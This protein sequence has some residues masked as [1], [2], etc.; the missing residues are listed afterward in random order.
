MPYNGS[1][2][3]NSLGVPTFPAVTGEYILA[4][5]FNATM[6][7]VF[8]GLS[9]ALPRDG[10]AAMS[11]ALAMANFK[12]TGLAN[13]SNP[14]DAV[15]YSQVFSGGSF[16][17]PVL[18]GVVNG[19]GATSVTVPSPTYED[20]S[21][22][23]V[24][25]SYLVSYYAKLASP[26]LTGI[27]TAPTA[28]YGTDTDQ[29]ATMAAIKDAI[30]LLP[31]GALPSVTGKD[32]TW[33][34]TPNSGGT[35]V[36][37]T[38]ALPTGI[39]VA[40]VAGGTLTRGNVTYAF[41]ANASYTLPDFTG[42]SNFGLLAPSNAVSVPATVTTSDGWTLTT[43]MVAGTFRHIVPLSAATAH[44]TWGASL[45]TPPTIS[46]ITGSAPLTVVATAS[47]S[48][49]LMIVMYQNSSNYFAVAVNPTTGAVG[50]PV[51]L[52]TYS[53][54]FTF[55]TT[56][57]VENSTTFVA[58]MNVGPSTASAYAGSVSGLTITLGS[59]LA[60]GSSMTDVAI[61]LA[62]GSYFFT[63]N[64]AY[65]TQ[66]LKAATLSG[67]TFTSALGI[68]YGGSWAQS[69]AR[70][71]QVSAT[72][73]LV[74]YCVAASPT[75]LRVRVA[76][77]SGTTVTVA[78]VVDSAT[79]VNADN[80]SS[81]MVYMLAQV[82]STYLVCCK[83]SSVSTT[84]NW[85][86]ITVSGT[87]PTIGTVTPR[88]NNLYASAS[89]ADIIC[90]PTFYAYQIP[91]KQATYNSTTWIG[92][93][94]ASGI[95]VVTISGT[96]LTFGTPSVLPSATFAVDATTGTTVYG[97]TS[98][99]FAD[100]TISGTTVTL[101]TQVTVNAAPAAINSTTLNNK[102]VNYSGV[103]YTWNTGTPQ[104]LVSPSTWLAA[105]GNNLLIQGPIA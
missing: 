1:G 65:I 17:D 87:T 16:T 97:L 82:G 30:D 101:G 35:A 47:L 22:K 50:T 32:T 39:L 79:A 44:G 20:N 90:F 18:L 83:D 8:L 21:Q 28:A 9:T 34:L 14:Q 73:V 42:N 53:A 38:Q 88:T 23:A 6:N 43:G 93:H 98:S 104:A 81:Y 96:T 63:L 46:T 91:K 33:S 58:V 40:P 25:T 5:Y 41:I 100:F 3:F 103:W 49:S 48:A 15:T 67:T 105:S 70:T 102:A 19:A 12:I 54:T 37:W 76:T 57:L 61:R 51:T 84:G 68:A 75:N 13:G 74:L 24:P 52:G 56:L 71:M 62:A 64:D 26:A 27:P 11:A 4:S 92:G 89:P 55:T 72:T 78:A 45:Q 80:S 59:A 95:Q 85:Y 36:Q 60:L 86:G 10:Q 99:V 7:D 69:H 94:L 29:I 77:I 2:T 31:S 66:N